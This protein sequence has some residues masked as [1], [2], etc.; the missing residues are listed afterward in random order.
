MRRTKSTENLQATEKSEA[1][2]DLE[3]LSKQDM[4]S[5]HDL[6]EKP[7]EEQQEETPMEQEEKAAQEVVPS[8]PTV[9]T[10]NKKPEVSLI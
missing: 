2:E 1:T 4:G 10:V 5:A 7:A 6:S 8:E 3:G 9:T